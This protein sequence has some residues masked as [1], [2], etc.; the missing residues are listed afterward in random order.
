MEVQWE[1]GG[2]SAAWTSRRL[3]LRPRPL[4]L[5]LQRQG[6]VDATPSPQNLGASI[7]KMRYHGPSMGPNS[8]SLYNQY[9][10][11]P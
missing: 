4:E 3:Q 6:W 9:N 11:G 8:E 5:V 1:G 2:R 10:R 7:P